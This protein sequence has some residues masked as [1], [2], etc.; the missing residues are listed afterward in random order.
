[1][2]TI[3]QK[4]CTEDRMERHRKLYSIQ[5]LRAIAAGLVV[6]FH[7]QE[8]VGRYSDADSILNGF[9]YLDHFGVS[10]VHIFF[11]ISGFIMTVV[12][13]AYFGTNGASI[14]FFKRRLVRIVPIYWLY[15]SVVLLL[16]CL[17]YTLKQSDFDLIYTIKSYLFIPAKD[18]TSGELVPLLGQGWTLSY[19]MYFYVL[20][21]FFLQFR[22]RWFLPSITLFFSACIGLRMVLNFDDTPIGNLLTNPILIE[23]VFGCLVG[24]AFV[25]GRRPGPLV[26][27]GLIGLGC[28]CMMATIFR[29]DGGFS[30]V[31]VW[32][33]PAVCLVAGAANLERAVRFRTPRILVALGDSSYT[34]YLTHTFVLMVIGKLLKMG[35][36]TGIPIDIIILF[37]VGICVVSGHLAYLCI[38]KPTTRFL[39]YRRK[40]AA[41]RPQP[42][43]SP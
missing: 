2:G 17:P 34:L 21:A 29:G 9:Y 6:L 11:V 41:I 32:G 13:N 20:F 5:A 15:T 8:V 3:L 28:L 4:D 31:V 12:S 18:P 22:R 14:E 27:V 35:L 30:R 33:L 38:E 36:L 25:S 40:L 1:M 26:S 42:A 10:G 23:F 7:T 39:T 37:S 16:V 19:E 43:T 24:T